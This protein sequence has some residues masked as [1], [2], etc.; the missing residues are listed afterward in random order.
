MAVVD[1]SI[2]CISV[3]TIRLVFA[4]ISSITIMCP[5]NLDYFARIFVVSGD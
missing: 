3:G 4:S 2:K 5:I 1:G